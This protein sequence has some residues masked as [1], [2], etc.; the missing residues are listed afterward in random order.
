MGQATSR[1]PPLI[2]RFDNDRP[3]IKPDLT[4]SGV[5]VLPL[6]IFVGK[7]GR[8]TEARNDSLTPLDPRQFELDVPKPGEIVLAG[9]LTQG[10]FR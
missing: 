2:R 6:H 1:R 10:D 8:N 3:R 9:V 5:S 7:A 4:K